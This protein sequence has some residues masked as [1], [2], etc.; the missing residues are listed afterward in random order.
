MEG[1]T[2]TVGWIQF[3]RHSA[4]RER[5]HSY[6]YEFLDLFGKALRTSDLWLKPRQGRVHAR[7]PRGALFAAV[8]QRV[9][10]AREVRIGTRL[11]PLCRDA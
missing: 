2:E 11:L 4:R 3:A 8:C 7:S 6:P 9:V 1:F 10:G 5:P